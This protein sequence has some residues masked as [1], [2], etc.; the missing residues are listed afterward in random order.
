M[1]MAAGGATPVVVLLPRLLRLP[2]L[3]L[4]LISLLQTN[5]CNAF[6]VGAPESACSD[7]LVPANHGQ[8]ITALPDALPVTFDVYGEFTSYRVTHFFPNHTYDC[9]TG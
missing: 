5:P 7:G 4:L 2:R 8:A 9:K 1:M 3:L 6:G